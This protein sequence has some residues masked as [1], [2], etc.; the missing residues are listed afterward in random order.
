MFT[1]PRRSCVAAQVPTPAIASAAERT[2]KREN[3]E[4][5]CGGGMPNRHRLSGP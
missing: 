3:R 1:V 4:H 2:G 5:E